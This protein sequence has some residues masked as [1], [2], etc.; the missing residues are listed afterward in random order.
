ME[1]TDGK[2][3]WKK[4][5]SNYVKLKN[6]TEKHLQL[7]NWRD[8]EWFN[9]PRPGIRFD[10]LFEDGRGLTAQPKTYT[11]TSRRLINTLRP[12]IESAMVEGRKSI[13]VRIMR[14]GEGMDTQYFVEEIPAVIQ[15][16]LSDQSEQIL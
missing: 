9:P 5:E 6:G 12:I 2:I 14:N 8:G 15:V 3:N 7:A 4:F 11:V 1:I 10:V 16:N 13:W